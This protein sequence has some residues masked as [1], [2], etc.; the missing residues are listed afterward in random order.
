MR[1]TFQDRSA[2]LGQES[3]RSTRKR[4]RNDFA[5]SGLSVWRNANTGKC[6]FLLDQDADAVVP[7]GCRR[8]KLLKAFR[9][10]PRFAVC[11]FLLLYEAKIFNR[12]EAGA[13]CEMRPVFRAKGIGCIPNRKI[14]DKN[15]KR[16]F[17]RMVLVFSEGRGRFVCRQK[18]FRRR[19]PSLS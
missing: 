3:G 17:K 15:R 9:P 12:M 19:W 7:A 16:C 14:D 4:G 2:V 5:A 1:W 11:F 6:V 8:L 13:V 18:C 10:K